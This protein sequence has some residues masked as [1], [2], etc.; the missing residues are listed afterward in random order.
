MFEYYIEVLVWKPTNTATFTIYC[1]PALLSW[2][3]AEE[4]FKGFFCL[5]EVNIFFSVS[6]VYS[7]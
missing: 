3:L 6:S 7:V 1:R 5:F 2:I 4:R